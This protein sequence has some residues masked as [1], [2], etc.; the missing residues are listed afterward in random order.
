MAWPHTF[1]ISGAKQQKGE[2]LTKPCSLEEKRKVCVRHIINKQQFPN[3]NTL[4]GPWAMVFHGPIISLI[5]A[6]NTIHKTL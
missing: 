6:Y 1:F 5:H 4:V 3:T 2:L